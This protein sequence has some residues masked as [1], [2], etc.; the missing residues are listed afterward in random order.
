MFKKLFD[1]IKKS[2]LDASG[3]TS[4]SRISSYFILGSILT[5]TLL[6]ITIDIGNAILYWYQGKSYVIPVEHIGI[7]GLILS[8]HL[9]LLG[10]KS[11]LESKIY[12]N[13]NYAQTGNIKESKEDSEQNS[14]EQDI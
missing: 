5:S 4:H 6:F 10:I 7:F 14:E 12:S 8:H 3:K 1:Y 2:I 9:M 13:G 11:N